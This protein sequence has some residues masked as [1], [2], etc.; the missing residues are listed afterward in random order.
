MQSK[1]DE[2]SSTSC[3]QLPTDSLLREFETTY[4]L[5][6]SILCSDNCTCPQCK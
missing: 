3:D 6:N 4:M 2:F 5:S 1:D